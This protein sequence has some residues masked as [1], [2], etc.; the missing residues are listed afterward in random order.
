MSEQTASEMGKQAW[1][2]SFHR[3]PAETE[4]SFHGWNAQKSKQRDGANEKK[5]KEGKGKIAIII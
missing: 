3:T 2:L 4:C 5:K 1:W